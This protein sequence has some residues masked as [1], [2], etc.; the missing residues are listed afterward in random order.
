[1]I[2]DIDLP[3]KMKLQ[4]LQRLK[5]LEYINPYCTRSTYTAAKI[6]HVKDNVRVTVR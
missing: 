1:M 4:K 2:M 5:D 3:Y 6:F